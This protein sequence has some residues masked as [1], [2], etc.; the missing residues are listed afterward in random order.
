MNQIKIGN[1]LMVK[2]PEDAKRFK[3]RKDGTKI[4]YN[5]LRATNK[6]SLTVKK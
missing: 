3:V 6:D 2:V 5:R 1:G 4:T